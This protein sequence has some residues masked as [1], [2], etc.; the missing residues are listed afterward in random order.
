MISLPRRLFVVPGFSMTMI[1]QSLLYNRR[2]NDSEVVVTGIDN[3]V[4]YIGMYVSVYSHFRTCGTTTSLL[5]IYSA[6]V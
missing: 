5:C 1:E 2:R 4:D 6:T 3:H